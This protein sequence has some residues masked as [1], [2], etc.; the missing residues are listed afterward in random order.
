M[1][2]LAIIYLVIVLFGGCSS[3][4]SEP[5]STIDKE[6]LLSQHIM[7]GL[8]DPQMQALDRS[9]NNLQAKVAVGCS[10]K[11]T[12]AIGDLRDQWK[13][14]MSQY[15]Y[16]ATFNHGPL[17]ID[18]GAVAEF[19]YSLPGELGKQQLI[20]R[21]I[22]K[23]EKSQEKYKIRKEKTT[24]LGLDSMEYVL[25]ERLE[26]DEELNSAL[27]ECVYLD[28]LAQDIKSRVN[29]VS[30]QW[31]G[32]TLPNYLSPEVQSN[33]KDYNAELAKGIIVYTDKVLKDQKIGA[34]LGLK[35]AESFK[36][37]PGESCHTLYLEHSYSESG[38]AALI[39]QL[40]A[41][42]DVFSGQSLSGQTK[43]F[44]FNDYLQEMDVALKS[45]NFEIG[46]HQISQAWQALPSG[47]AYEQL[48]AE[49]GESNN[50]E[51]PVYQAYLKVRDLSSWLKTEFIVDLSS[52]LPGA[53]QGDND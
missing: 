46:Q 45:I 38:Q 44:G 43:N 51:N 17:A 8:M 39:T 40:R 34:P 29:R 6:L 10:D 20:D 23:A 15:H 35:A 32:E 30:D 50:N 36:C 41:L 3:T 33:L 21:E 25:F 11:E 26:G 28:Y 5:V 47:A 42:E 53:V 27:Q 2:Y 31:R 49:Y 13:L 37:V 48:F 22:K 52:Q 16:L 18:N 1:K 4:S 19:I 12:V 9:V 24:I 7:L 14:V